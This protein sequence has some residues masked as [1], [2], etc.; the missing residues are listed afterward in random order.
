MQI[1]YL[2]YC[3]AQ[4][5]CPVCGQ[6]SVQKEQEDEKTLHFIYLCKLFVRK[7]FNSLAWQR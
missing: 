3:L 6:W 5:Q 7:D 4:S 2:T 1:R